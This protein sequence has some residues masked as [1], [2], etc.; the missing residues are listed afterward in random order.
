KDLK[1][2]DQQVKQLTQ[3]YQKAREMYKA[4]FD[5]LGSIPEKD[6]YHRWWEL[7]N[8]VNAEFMKNAGDIFNKDQM[9]RYR[10]LHLQQLGPEAFYD[11]QVQK[12]LN[13]T[14]EQM[15]QLRELGQT[16]YKE[17]SGIFGGKLNKAEVMKRWEALNKQT[18]GGINKILNEQRKQWEE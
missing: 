4:D 16:N 17:L 15:K 13:L 11:P 3:A 5:K 12:K 2:T 1:F 6:R 7:H 8:N 10:Q 18:T 14:D 9:T